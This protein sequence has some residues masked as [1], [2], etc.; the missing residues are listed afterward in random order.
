MPV[1]PLRAPYLPPWGWPLATTLKHRQLTAWIDMTSNTL[2]VDTFSCTFC[3]NDRSTF[4]THTEQSGKFYVITY[5]CWIVD[6]PCNSFHP[7][8]NRGPC[9]ACWYACVLP[10]RQPAPCKRLMWCLL[11]RRYGLQMNCA[12]TGLT[13]QRSVIRSTSTWVTNVG[14]TGVIE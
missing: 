1:S 7:S 5:D 11:C 10:C 14:S 9:P 12:W 6:T 2:F 4:L 8:L 13:E 3:N